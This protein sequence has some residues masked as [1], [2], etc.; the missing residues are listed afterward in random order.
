MPWGRGLPER[1]EYN[2]NFSDLFIN[3]RFRRRFR[4]FL[5]RSG[6]NFS[7]WYPDRDFDNEKVENSITGLDLMK[8]KNGREHHTG[9]Y[10]TLNCVVR[11]GQVFTIKASLSRKLESDEVVH[12]RFQ[13]IID[14]PIGGPTGTTI[15][16]NTTTDTFD[17]DLRRW[18]YRISEQKDSYVMLEVFAPYNAIVCPWKVTA[19]LKKKDGEQI[20][21]HTCKEKLYMLFNPWNKNDDVYISND[22]ERE[23]YVMNEDGRIYTGSAYW[24]YA[25]PWEFGQFESPVLEVSMDLLDKAQLSGPNRSYPVYVSRAITALVNSSD[26]DDGVLIGNWSGDYSGGVSPSSWT[27][28]VEIFENYLNNGEKPVAY[29]Q[30]WVFSGIVTSIMRALGIPCRSVTNFD[31]AHDTDGNMTKDVIYDEN[32]ERTDYHNDS[33][34]NFHVWNEVWMKRRDLDP[35]YNGWQIIDGTPQEVSGDAYQLGPCPQACVLD[36]N[37]HMPYDAKFVFAEVNSDIVHWQWKGG[38]YNIV[39]ILK[40]EVGTAVLT[41]AVGYNSKHDI[42]NLYKK[43]EG[44]AEERMAVMNAVSRGTNEYMYMNLEC[45]HEDVF[46]N[47]TSSDSLNLLADNF[48]F[49]IYMRNDGPEKRSIKSNVVTKKT[50]YTGVGAR[51]IDKQIYDEKLEAGEEKQIEHM[52]KLDDVLMGANDDSTVKV[53]LTSHVQETGQLLTKQILLPIELP[54]VQMKV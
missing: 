8:K 18:Q 26:D 7:P 43:K 45:F 27:G 50:Q 48:T 52:V 46:V 1:S 23:E 35:G 4:R 39:K 24:P 30:C 53:Q 31:S 16:L 54:H 37:V 51:V 47:L 2:S 9:E 25:K 21:S 28:S 40:D 15:Q 17:E 22:K 13:C 32:M 42:T 5:E 11:R 19:V 38:E 44:S 3:R 14:A 29:G 34:W 6:R 49:K 12:M 20:D 33:I 36:G 10:E 41:K